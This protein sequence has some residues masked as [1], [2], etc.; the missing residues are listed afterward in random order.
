[1]ATA[2]SGY[3]HEENGFNLS[4]LFSFLWQKKIRIVF[5]ASLIFVLGAYY[6]VNQPKVYVAHSTLLLGGSENR[7]GI[8]SNLNN[9]GSSDAV[10]MDTYIEFIRS[11]QFIQSIVRDLNLQD[12]DE[13]KRKVPSLF[14]NDEIEYAIDVFQGNLLLTRM[15]DTDLLKVSYESRLPGLA[16]DVAN[17]VGPAFFVFNA[18]MSREK[19]NDA[20]KWLNTQLTQLQT[21]LANS[22]DALQAF[23]KENKLIDVG[24][25]I[26]LARTEISALL[27]EKL[28]ID[29]QFADVEATMQQLNAAEEDQESL[30]RVPW[31]L[32]NSL[33][34]TLHNKVVN[35]EQEFATLTNRYKSKHHKYIA[36]K[37]KLTQLL[38]E[39]QD[40]LV[41]LVASLRQQYQTLKSRSQAL[42]Q[43]IDDA[44]ER[45]S[46]LGRHELQLSRLR[47]DVESTQTLYEVFLSRLQETEILKDL[48]DSEQFAVVDYAVEPRRPSKPNIP[49]LLVMVFVFSFTLSIG[50]W[51]LLHLLSDRRNRYRQ[52]LSKMGVSL[53]AELPKLGKIN[54]LKTPRNSSK[55]ARVRYP[56][57]EAVRSLRSSIMVRPDDKEVRAVAISSVSN[58][59]GKSDVAIALAESFSNLEKAL[60]ID[61]DLR[62]PSVAKKFDL[63]KKHPGIVNFVNRKAK[64][65]LCMHR[66]ADTQ[67]TIMPCGDVPSDPIAHLSKPRFGSII[68][69]LGVFFERVVIDSPPIN[70]FSDTLMLAKHVDGVVIVCDIEKTDIA[71]L[72]EAIQRMRDSGAHLLG[73]VLSGVKGISSS[74]PKASLR[75][76]IF[77]KAFNRG[78]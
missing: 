22:E 66:M 62:A 31:V 2:Q 3:S 5:T 74:L 51:L 77:G 33:V 57:D 11:R 71:D 34:V 37:S 55:Y 19:A 75:K 76:R 58:K 28:Q 15:G 65:S 18:S 43:Q 20:S 7:F 8:Q 36:S 46:D 64:I 49:V 48:D 26:E 27:N 39:Q 42:S 13:F 16:A 53:L 14:D 52:Q 17:F 69:K 61:C 40:L 9:F 73:V 32:Q 63:A 6:V 12:A 23:L 67:L 56:Y 44:K 68:Y 72:A 35:Q 54:L 78:S 25:Q 24:S 30:L 29:K 10:K 70:D 38:D 59:D 47:R 1:M 41:K 45:Y 4:D 50:L 60:L 21:K